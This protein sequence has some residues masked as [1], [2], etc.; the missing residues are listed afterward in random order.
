MH[1]RFDTMDTLIS[2]L[3]PVKFTLPYNIKCAS[4]VMIYKLN[5]T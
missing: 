2:T 4:K 3:R 5:S 1:Y